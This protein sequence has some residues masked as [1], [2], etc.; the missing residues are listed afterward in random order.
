MAAEANAGTLALMQ[1]LLA[2][3]NGSVDVVLRYV[4]QSEVV[5]RQRVECELTLLQHKPPRVGVV[6]ETRTPHAHTQL[7]PQKR[8]VG[9]IDIDAL[10]KTIAT[11]DT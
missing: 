8:G 9:R 5:L 7:Q 6:L 1:C 11:V 3:S 2:L 4:S 10:V